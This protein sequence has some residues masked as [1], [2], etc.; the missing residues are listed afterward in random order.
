M[1][2]SLLPQDMMR[3]QLPDNFLPMEYSSCRCSPAVVLKGW[4]YDICKLQYETLGSL[5]LP[6]ALCLEHT[7][8]EGLTCVT[9]LAAAITAIMNPIATSAAEKTSSLDE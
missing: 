9:E 4:Q 6:S 5:W 3:G 8:G 7:G 2:S 1:N